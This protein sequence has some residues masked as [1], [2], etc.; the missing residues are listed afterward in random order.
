[1]PMVFLATTATG[2]ASS[3]VARRRERL[4]ATMSARHQRSK[5]FDRPLEQIDL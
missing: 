4:V 5:F 3:A 2:I 1:M